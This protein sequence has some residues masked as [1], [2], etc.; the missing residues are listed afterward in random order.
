M[1]PKLGVGGAVGVA[2]LR[3][4]RLG[5]LIGILI[6]DRSVDGLLKDGLGLIDLE[7]GLQIGD[8]VGEAAAV[9]AAAGIRELEWLIGDVICKTAPVVLVC[10]RD[11]VLV[12]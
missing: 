11:V 8:V 12:R 1:G 2:A 5:E 10:Q 6:L 3:R 7:L 9:G 4:V